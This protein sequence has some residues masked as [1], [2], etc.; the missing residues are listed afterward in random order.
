LKFKKEISLKSKNPILLA[1]NSPYSFL[2]L[3]FHII[4][5][6]TPFPLIGSELRTLVTDPNLVKEIFSE[7]LE[8]SKLD[9]QVITPKE[10]VGQFSLAAVNGEEWVLHPELLDPAFHSEPIKVGI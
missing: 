4:F 5:H 3:F 2:L 10:M 1:L 9:V 7:P 8:H 6:P